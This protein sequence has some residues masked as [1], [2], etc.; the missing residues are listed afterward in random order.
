MAAD[1]VQDYGD[2]GTL[3]EYVEVKHP[4]E[5]GPESMRIR[6][7]RYDPDVHELAEGEDPPSG[8][9][10]DAPE[11]D[12]ALADLVGTR[13]ANAF[14]KAGITTIDEALEHEG[15]LTDLDGIGQ[16]TVDDLLSAEE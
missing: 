9:D 10:E 12:E 13:Q 1:S 3:G 15:D 14:A 2:D 4:G 7:D 6:A 11:P 16:S 5:H 8:T